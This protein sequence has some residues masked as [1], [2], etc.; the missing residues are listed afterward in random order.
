M[1][2][3]FACASSGVI[4]SSGSPNVFA[5]PAW[6][7]SSSNRSF[8][9]ASRSDP[10]SCHETSTPVSAVRRRYS[11]APYIIIRV[12][13]VV[14]RSWPTRPAEWNVEPDVSSARSTRTTSFQPSSVR[15]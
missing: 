7:W 1:S 3:N 10:T 2:G 9:D 15:W 5:Q 4:S 12:R 6:R 13:V 8:E 14:D 11:S